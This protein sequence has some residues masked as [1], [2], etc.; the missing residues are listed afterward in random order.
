M[1]ILHPS[2]GEG[3]KVGQA[4]WEGGHIL[5]AAALGNLS[6][7]VALSIS[8]GPAQAG[9]L[10]GNVTFTLPAV[11]A[12]QTEHITLILTNGD[13][14]IA[15]TVAGALWIG[16]EAPDLDDSDEAVNVITLRGIAG[17]WFADGGTAE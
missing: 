15:I 1:K 4:E 5:P 14:G 13:E 2:P 7:T 10:T 9:V 8:D 16:G 3:E 17:Q 11:P 6:G 12:G